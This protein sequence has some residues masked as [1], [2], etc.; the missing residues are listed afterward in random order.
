MARRATLLGTALLLQIGCSS[1]TSTASSSGFTTHAPPPRIVGSGEQKPAPPPITWFEIPEAYRQL[2]EPPRS[3]I[4]DCIAR[5]KAKDEVTSTDALA[6]C[7]DIRLSA[8]TE[9]FLG[10]HQLAVREPAHLYFA[11]RRSCLIG[12]GAKRGA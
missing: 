8:A 7:M 11:R 3:A 5:A 4:A 9:V 12:L 10:C 1:C 2:M 6:D